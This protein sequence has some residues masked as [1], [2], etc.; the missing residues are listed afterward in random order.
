MSVWKVFVV[1]CDHPDECV[2]SFTGNAYE[3]RDTVL[4]AVQRANWRVLDTAHG[5]RH[6]CPHHPD[7]DDLL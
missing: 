4:K 5:Q 2:T 3:D 6:I 1:T 7:P